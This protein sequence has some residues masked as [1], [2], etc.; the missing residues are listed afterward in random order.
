MRNR[1]LYFESLVEGRF[2]LILNKLEWK[3]FILMILNEI[4]M[5]DE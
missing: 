5:N 3:D 2:E 1:N 4:I